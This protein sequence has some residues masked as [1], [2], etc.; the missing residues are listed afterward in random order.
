MRDLAFKDRAEYHE[1][2]NRIMEIGI[3]MVESDLSAS[4]EQWLRRASLIKELRSLG[5]SIIPLDALMNP[6]ADGKDASAVGTKTGG[7][8]SARGYEVSFLADVV[9]LM[10]A[11]SSVHL[12]NDSKELRLTIVMPTG[13]TSALLEFTCHFVDGFLS[14]YGYR[15]LE[16]QKV[17]TDFVSLKYAKS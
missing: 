3:K 5:Y 15:K 13:S 10:I 4:V 16:E 1:T 9:Q 14:S 12:I 7:F 2:A 17:S 6:N 11:G 8:L